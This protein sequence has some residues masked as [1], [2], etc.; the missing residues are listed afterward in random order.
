MQLLRLSYPKKF[1]T[2]GPNRK[3]FKKAKP[4]L[5]L[6][7]NYVIKAA[8]LSVMFSVSDQA[9][10]SSGSILRPLKPDTILGRSDSSKLRK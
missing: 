6:R 5:I 3:K 10:G 1:P 7:A 9:R 2:L 8:W 4:G